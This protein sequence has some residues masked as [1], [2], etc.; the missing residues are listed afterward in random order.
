M[1]EFRADLKALGP[2]W[3]KELS[4]VHK[5]IATAAAKD[6]QATAQ[7]LGGVQAKAA[8]KIKGS[9]T[10]TGASITVS[11]IGNVAFWGAIKRTGWYAAPKYAK[12][13]RQHP[14][15]VG[16]NWDVAVSGEGPYAINPT[17]AAHMDEYLDDFGEGID[18][19]AARAFP[20]GG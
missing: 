7:G 6:S 18:E 13:P 10:L 8:S 4:K 1:R 5:K 17:L 9:G 12:S 16:A 11:G 2:E 20:E 14:E 19:L 3:P 15:W